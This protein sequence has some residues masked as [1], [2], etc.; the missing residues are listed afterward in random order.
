MILTSIS[1]FCEGGHFVL[2]PSHC[3]QIFNSSK[4]GVQAFSYLFSCFGFS[5]IAGSFV[6]SYILN[7]CKDSSTDG[8]YVIFLLASFMNVIALSTLVSYNKVLQQAEK[9]NNCFVRMEEKLVT[10]EMADQVDD[11]YQSLSS[12]IS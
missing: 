6:S 7:K 5:S 11:N 3:A 12:N 8:Y 4:K 2:V 10:I 9:D 1:M